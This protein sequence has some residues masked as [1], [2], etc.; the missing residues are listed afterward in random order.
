M[1][2][3]LYFPLLLALVIQLIGVTL[4]VFFPETLHL[5][6]LPEPRDGQDASIEL[7]TKD[8]GHGFKTQLKHFK[9]AFLLLKS[10]F[11]L[12]LV[13]CIF[14]VNRLGRQALTLLIRYASKRYNWEISKVRTIHVHPL[15]TA[16]IIL[17]AA[18]LLSF[19]AAT[20]LVAVAIF[21]PL[22]NIT[23]IKYL[24]LPVHWAD[25][26]L[27]RGSL[28]VTAIGFFA[29]ALAFQPAILILGL[30]IFNLGTGSSAAMRSVSLHVIGGQS[31][32]DVGKL[33][34]LVAVSENIGTMFAGPLLNEALKKGM[35]L[36]AAW[37]GLPFFGA[38]LLYILATVLSFIVSVKDKDVAYVEVA[39][40]EEDADGLSSALEDRPLA[41][42]TEH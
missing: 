31:S 39:T 1:K 15:D 16:L 2:T 3:G 14:V 21:I 38:V 42:Q 37:L 9:S 20:N 34:S 12:A 13:V 26:W 4:G 36:G 32:P 22:V 24:R 40:D 10:D 7:Q 11:T 27:M 18:Y 25:L 5:R 33:M 17:Q 19:R 6:D 29:I 28:L 23:L 41:R 35:D 8:E 30:L